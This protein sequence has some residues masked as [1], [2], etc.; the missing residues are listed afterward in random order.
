ML[1]WR[2]GTGREALSREQGNLAQAVKSSDFKATALPS[3]LRGSHQLLS[4]FAFFFFNSQ[5]YKGHLC[6]FLYRSPHSRWDGGGAA[7]VV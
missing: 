1:Q 3:P 7:E 4:S 6:L 2:R 5:T